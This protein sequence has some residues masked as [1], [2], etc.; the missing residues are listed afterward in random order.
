[1]GGRPRRRAVGDAVGSA[2][3][4]PRPAEQEERLRFFASAAEFTPMIVV[5]NPSGMFVVETAD[6]TVGRLLFVKGG[7]REF[8]AVEKAVSI[9]RAAGGTPGEFIDVGANVGTSV[10]TALRLHGFTGA[11]AC[12]PAPRNYRLLRTNL[13]LNDVAERA[14]TLPVAVSDQVGE[15]QLVLN[16]TNSGAHRV[17]TDS[18]PLAQEA[19][20]DT[21]AVEAVTL[22]LLAERDLV[23]PG[24]SE[25][26]WMDV[27]GHEAHVLLG[28]RSLV[29]AGVSIVLELHP[30]LLRAA[31]KLD[32]LLDLIQQRYSHFVDLRATD[33]KMW[34][35]NRITALAAALEEREVYT[36]VVLLR[37]TAD[38]AAAWNAR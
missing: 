7:R 22:D 20:F 34:P 6:E 28:A 35:S 31:G 37:R 26:L 4:T 23:E 19:E 24:A 12:E 16:P 38:Q 13:V 32:E 21:V 18:G 17:L 25:L 30:Q 1:M 14:R 5:E 36:D 29:D 11:L 33:L 8:S 15:L 3:T 9:V 2:V 10:V 27:Q